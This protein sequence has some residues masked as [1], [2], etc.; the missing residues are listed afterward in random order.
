M[1]SKAVKIGVG[2]TVAIVVVAL[3]VVGIVVGQGKKDDPVH[4]LQVDPDLPTGPD[5]KGN[6]F[7]PSPIF[8][9]F[10]P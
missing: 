3:I 6:I 10:C 8:Y 9:Q 4:Q 5:I 1:V 7:I 2:V